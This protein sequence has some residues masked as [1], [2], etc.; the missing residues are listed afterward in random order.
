MLNNQINKLL[1]FANMQMA[2]EAFLVELGDSGI[3]DIDTLR[4]RLELGNT[5]A[6]R[7]T[8]VQAEQFTAQY[9]VLAQY[10]NDPLQ[11]GGTGFSATLFKI[12]QQVPESNCFPKRK[13]ESTPVPF[14]T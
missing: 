8:P 10:R 5:H 11:A 1:E 3:P 12:R 2:S 4:R 9:Q 7:F 13:I 14:V 6:S